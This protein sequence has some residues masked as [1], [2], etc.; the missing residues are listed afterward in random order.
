M[1]PPPN[2][3]PGLNAITTREAEELLNILAASR[4]AKT[5]KD[6]TASFTPRLAHMLR[7]GARF[8]ITRVPAE[9]YRACIELNGCGFVL[10]NSEN[11][12]A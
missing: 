2:P 6:F 7:N 9:L 5:L 1:H 11:K 12:V 4:N 3:L 10:Y 8:F